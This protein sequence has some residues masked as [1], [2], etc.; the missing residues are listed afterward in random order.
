MRKG[1]HFS[2]RSGKAHERHCFCV[3]KSAHFFRAVY[4]TAFSLFAVA[5]PHVGVQQKFRSDPVRVCSEDNLVVIDDFL[6]R[7]N[8]LQNAILGGPRSHGP[9]TDHCGV[10]DT[11]TCTASIW[12]SSEILPLLRLPLRCFGRGAWRANWQR[13]RQ[14]RSANLQALHATGDIR[15]H[16]ETGQ[17]QRLES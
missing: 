10:F 17:T 3:V 8:T 1:C 2:A 12:R 7:G 5:H 6:V 16:R 11:P 4:R 13:D 15:L 9:E 14:P